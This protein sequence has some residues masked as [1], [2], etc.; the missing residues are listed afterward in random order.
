MPGEELTSFEA[1]FLTT[2]FLISFYFCLTFNY[3]ILWLPYQR[4]RNFKKRFMM[5]FVNNEHKVQEIFIMVYYS[6]VFYIISYL[7]RFDYYQCAATFSLIF[8]FVICYI[9]FR[10]ITHFLSGLPNIFQYISIWCF[11]FIFL[12][13]KFYIIF[14]YFF[15]LIL[16]SFFFFEPTDPLEPHKDTDSFFKKW[17]KDQAIIEYHFNKEFYAFRHIRSFTYSFILFF[18]E[19]L[20]R[21]FNVLPFSFFW[22]EENFGHALLMAHFF[23]IFS[24][25]LVLFIQGIV[26]KYCNP[27]TALKTRH[28]FLITAITAIWLW[29]QGQSTFILISAFF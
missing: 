28:I 4:F 25:F 6:C 21:I 1:L 27:V 29:C 2:F 9:M 19:N 14:C 20:K 13:L 10:F 11:L 23:V 7:L 15:L 24:L 5:K 22:T 8:V 26:V 3:L 17:W 16:L 12:Y 18:S